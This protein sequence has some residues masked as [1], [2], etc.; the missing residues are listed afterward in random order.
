MSNHNLCFEQKYGKYQ[1]FSAKKNPFLDVKFSIYLNRRVFGMD[2]SEHAQNLIRVFAG[3]CVGSQ[4]Y[5]LQADIENSDQPVR[6]C[7]ST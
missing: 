4:R 5:G 2:H 3:H 1:N 6:I 7:S